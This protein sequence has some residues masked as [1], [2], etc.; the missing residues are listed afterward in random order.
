MSLAGNDY[1]HATVQRLADL[2][3]TSEA[4]YALASQSADKRLLK[5]ELENAAQVRAHLL[6]DVEVLLDKQHIGH[7]RVGP[8]AQDLA[9][10][11][12][13]CEDSDDDILQA[14]DTLAQ[15]IVPLSI[16]QMVRST[17]ERLDQSRRR[18]RTCMRLLRLRTAHETGGRGLVLLAGFDEER[19]ME[20]ASELAERGFDAE[21]AAGV[22]EALYRAILQDP[23]AVAVPQGTDNAM[24][25]AL[26]LAEIDHQP[27]ILGVA[28]EADAGSLVQDVLSHRDV[29]AARPGVLVVEDDADLRSALAQALSERG[30][31]V[32]EAIDGLDALQKL[33]KIGKDQPMV[34]LLDLMM[35][36]MSGVSFLKEV[37]KVE[38]PPRVVVYSA[39]VE[40]AAQTFSNVTAVLRKTAGIE[41]VV[42]ALRSSLS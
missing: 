7:A 3:A 24:G 33:E 17:R 28:R 14:L 16:D 36:R 35:P 11:L 4:A 8:P 25:E 40:P 15:M 41:A 12:G 30:F 19:T 42:E 13:R 37:A 18:M 23:V 31:V 22:G 39:Y 6:H 27:L 5:K 2:I 9:G 20:L 1:L 21:L 38:S 26:T 10:F 29:S 32:E 34:V